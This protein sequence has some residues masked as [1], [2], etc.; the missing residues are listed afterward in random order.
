MGTLIIKGL[1][2]KLANLPYLK[3]MKPTLYSESH[4]FGGPYYD[5]LVQVLQKLGFW[6]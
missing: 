3:P 4:V 5:F 1:L 6:G 2:G